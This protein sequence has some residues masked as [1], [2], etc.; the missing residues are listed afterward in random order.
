MA[1]KLDANQIFQS[2]YDESTGRLKVDTVAS[3]EAGTMEVAI[4]HADDSIKIGDGTDFLLVNADGSLNAVISATSLPLPTGAAT[5]ATLSTLSTNIAT[6]LDTVDSP[7]IDSHAV[8]D[9]RAV[10]FAKS[11]T[12]TYGNIERTNGGNL[13]VSIEEYEVPLPS[14]TNSIG[15]VSTKTALTPSAPTAATVGTSSAEV[16]ASNVDRKGLVLT[17]TSNNYISLGFGTSAILYSGITLSPWG[18]FVMDEYLFTTAQ[19]TAIASAA[20]SNLAIQEI[21]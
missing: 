12:G 14:G 19:V 3:V 13:K 21:E 20:A 16:V 1:T 5:Q 10:L 4:S 9:V 6:V 11:P 18:V 2:A 17:N 8:F 15:I 7:I